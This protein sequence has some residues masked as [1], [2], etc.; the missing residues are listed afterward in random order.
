[1]ETSRPTTH[2]DPTYIIDEVVHYCVANMPGAVG[3]TS[4][5]ALCNATLNWVI[6]LTQSGIDN[7]ANGQGPLR[8]AVNIHRGRLMNAAV[9][10]AFG[11][12]L[13]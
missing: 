12:P 10:D 5:F 8:E 3:R 7:I 1:V 13:R 9:A 11:I 2:S 6:R 4:T